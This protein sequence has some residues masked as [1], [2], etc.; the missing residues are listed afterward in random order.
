MLQS[1]KMAEAADLAAVAKSK[2]MEM[3]K[4]L[5]CALMALPVTTAH[6]A[7]EDTNSADFMLPF[8]RLTQKEMAADINKASN[9]SRC[10]GVVEGIS[11]M[12]SLL[13]EAQA[14]G[15]AR[16]DPLLCTSIPAG[17]TNEQLVNVVVKYGEA[18]PELTHRPFAVVAMSAM[19]LA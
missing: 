7:V 10:A 14:A 1:L 6:A 15:A 5:F 3:R 18:F 12:F 13:Q 2:G 17:I 16:L 9:Y 11:Q 8:C 19:R 4:M